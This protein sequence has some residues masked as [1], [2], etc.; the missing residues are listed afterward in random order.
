MLMKKNQ[1]G[2]SPI[3][4]LLIL[5]LVGLIG[6]VGWYV[7]HAKNSTD[8]FYSNSD[9]A[10]SAASASV[11]NGITLKAYSDDFVAFKYPAKWTAARDD[12]ISLPGTK[13]LNITGVADT[14]LTNS[15]DASSGQVIKLAI[16]MFKSPQL[17]NMQTTVYDVVD[18]SMAGHPNAKLVI[19]GSTRPAQAVDGPA[20]QISVTEASNV[21][22]GSTNIP[23]G[24]VVGSQ[25]VGVS[26]V[27]GE[28]NIKDLNSL[29]NT[30][31]F[32]DFVSLLNSTTFK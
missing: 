18:L 16:L 10:S 29:K 19:T 5:V 24:L 20:A 15:T 26:A 11:K 21:K 6:F 2:F 3:E 4:G 22:V 31:S 17:G 7:F 14:T 9:K 28:Y 1:R 13:T 23:D 25:V 27:A 12:N 8:S 32:M 30:Q